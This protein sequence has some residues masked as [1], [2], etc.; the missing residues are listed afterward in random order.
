MSGG[1][2]KEEEAD[3][4]WLQNTIHLSALPLVSTPDYIASLPF[5]YITVNKN[6]VLGSTPSDCRPFNFPPF[7]PHK[8]KVYYTLKQVNLQE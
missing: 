3:C 7:S 6:G 4:K 8:F 5:P 1:R 2:D